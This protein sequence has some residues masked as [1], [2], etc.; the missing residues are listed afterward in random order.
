MGCRNHH[1][2]MQRGQ[3]G[4]PCGWGKR[5]VVVKEGYRSWKYLKKKVPLRLGAPVT[6]T[7]CL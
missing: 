2:K 7:N 5:L 1:F 6:K 4:G 3:M